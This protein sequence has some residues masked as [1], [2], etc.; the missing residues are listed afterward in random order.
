MSTPAP[1]HHPH[2]AGLILPACQA[3]QLPGASNVSQLTNAHAYTSAKIHAHKHLHTH[4]QTHARKRERERER[5][6][7]RAVMQ[8]FLLCSRQTPTRPSSCAAAGRAHHREGGGLERGL[9][10]GPRRGCGHAVQRKRV[11]RGLPQ[12]L[13]GLQCVFACLLEDCAHARPRVCVYVFVHDH[14]TRCFG[15]RGPTCK[16]VSMYAC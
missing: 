11:A 3:A 16:P 14:I 8:L 9:C 6:R 13:Q 12:R 1:L 10:G 4:I 15:E 7:E 5:E 2:A